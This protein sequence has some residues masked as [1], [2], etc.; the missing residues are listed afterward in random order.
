MVVVIA[1][2]LA[3]RD[4]LTWPQKKDDRVVT[5]ISER[6]MERCPDHGPCILVALVE[7]VKQWQ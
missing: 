4:I 7:A 6:V 2:A 5:S 3:G 1:D